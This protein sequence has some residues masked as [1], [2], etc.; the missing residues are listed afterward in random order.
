MK[1][2]N[3]T[4][5]AVITVKSLLAEAAKAE[6]QNAEMFHELWESG[7]RNLSRDDQSKLWEGLKQFGVK[8]FAGKKYLADHPEA[9]A[10]T[11]N[12]AGKKSEGATESKPEK[13]STKKSEK[14]TAEA[15]TPEKKS[16]K[17]SAPKAPATT[18][19]A[20]ARIFAELQ[21]INTRLGA[22]EKQLAE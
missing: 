7:K 17:K 18:E 19:D 20:L 13:K 11:P 3:T 8:R 15:P 10:S 1:K 9:K 22:I 14:L 2:T 5:T 6:N 21:S 16:T 4:N 12:W